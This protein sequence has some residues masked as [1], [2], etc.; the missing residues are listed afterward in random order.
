MAA[1]NDGG[2]SI[3]RLCRNF[4]RSLYAFFYVIFYHDELSPSDKKELVA[5]ATR[6]LFSFIMMAA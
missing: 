6:R 1:A 5:H 2:I 3:V 4:A